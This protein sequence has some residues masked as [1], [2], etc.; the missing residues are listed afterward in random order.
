MF[1]NSKLRVFLRNESFCLVLLVEGRKWFATKTTRV[2]VLL[3]SRSTVWKRYNERV[4]QF[5]TAVQSVVKNEKVP[6]CS[7]VR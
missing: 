4:V 1:K 6:N 7:L 3:S 5:A 2:A